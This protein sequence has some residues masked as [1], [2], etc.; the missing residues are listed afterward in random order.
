MYLSG[1]E[2]WAEL[3]AKVPISIFMAEKLRCLLS[4]L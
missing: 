2:I 4:L 1:R 3:R